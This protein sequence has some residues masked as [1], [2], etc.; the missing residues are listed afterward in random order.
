M[1]A[2]DIATTDQLGYFTPNLS[3]NSSGAFAGR[4]SAAQVFIRGMGQLDYLP[5]TDPG[6]EVLRGPQGTL[7]GRNAVGGAVVLHSRRPDDRPR[8]SVRAEFG[9]DGMTN[10]TVLVSGPV[11]GGLYAGLTVALRK[12]DGYV[13]WVH[14][15]L[16]MGDDDGRAVRGTLVWPSGESLE[17]FAVADYSRRRE[18]GAPTVSGGVND[19]MAFGAF[20]NALLPGSIADPAGCGATASGTGRRP[21][22]GE[23]WTQSGVASD[24]VL[25][26]RR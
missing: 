22:T 7:F 10:G 4:K 15:G 25:P 14:D 23:S 24:A 21:T 8:R 18:N 26:T 19:R 13:T 16:D 11:A 5:V 12:R 9:S 1:E 2:Q 17:V 6:V 3:F 20:G